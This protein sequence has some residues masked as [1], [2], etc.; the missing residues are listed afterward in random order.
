MVRQ[1][2]RVGPGIAHLVQ[3]FQVSIGQIYRIDIEKAETKRDNSL[4]PDHDYNKGELQ[5]MAEQLDMERRLIGEATSWMLLKEMWTI[6]GNRKRALISIGLM[7]CQ[8]MTGTNT[9]VSEQTNIHFSRLVSVLR[10]SSSDTQPQ[11][12]YAPQ[13]FTNMGLQQAKA[14]LFATG[15]YGVVSHH[16][17]P[18]P[19]R[20][21]FSPRRFVS[22]VNT[23]LPKDENGVLTRIPPLRRR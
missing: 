10:I 9:L 7:V 14:S 20:N 11:N 15:V 5:D 12:Y 4:P 21:S 22:H 16:R 18:P 13:I 2:G 23:C 6:P 19:P 3:A 1:E 8:Q 17:T